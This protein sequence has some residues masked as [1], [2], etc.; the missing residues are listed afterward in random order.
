MARAK[1]EGFPTDVE[2]K[3]AFFMSEVAHGEA[4]CQDGKRE[5]TVLNLSEI[6]SGK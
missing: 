5:R 4:L 2:E 3:E 1:E 6:V